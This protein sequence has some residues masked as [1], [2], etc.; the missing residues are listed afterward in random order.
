MQLALDPG[1]LAGSEQRRN[2]ARER[3]LRAGFWQPSSNLTLARVLPLRP[4]S[5]SADPQL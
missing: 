2:A 5:R 1:S 3:I 4:P